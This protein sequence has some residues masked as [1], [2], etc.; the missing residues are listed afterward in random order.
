MVI[1]YKI[2]MTLYDKL[3]WSICEEYD[4]KF[5]RLASISKFIVR[6]RYELPTDE[7]KKTLRMG[8]VNVYIWKA[9]QDLFNIEYI[10]ELKVNKNQFVK[11]VNTY[12]NKNGFKDFNFNQWMYKDGFFFNLS[13]CMAT[14]YKLSTKIHQVG[15][16]IQ[17]EV[18]VFIHPSTKIIDI[19]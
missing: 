18:K 9:P 15:G 5:K 3:M 17:Y 2:P 6:N 7:N 8:G 10:I 4:S 12:M 19:N 14:K 11:F 1:D 13:E 16:Y